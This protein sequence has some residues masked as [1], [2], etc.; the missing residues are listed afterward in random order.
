MSNVIV[1][2]ER[3]LIREWMPEDI[4]SLHKIM[5][6]PDVMKYVWDYEPASRERVEDF[7]STCIDES[8]NRSWTIWPLVMKEEGNLI[9]Y[10]GFLVRNYGE[11]KGETE[12]GWLLEKKYWGKGLATEAAKAVLDFG[13]EKWSFKKVI[14]AARGE[15]KQSL[16]I[17]ENIGMK[18]VSPSLNP[19]GRLI[20]HWVIE[21]SRTQI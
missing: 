4:H 3:L 13:L 20:P 10:C 7:V 16:K 18:A 14:A 11:Y 8:L 19:K 2:T 17:M 21:N 5:S 15:N 1:E 12:M 6:D 9:G